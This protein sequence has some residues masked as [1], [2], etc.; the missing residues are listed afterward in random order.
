MGAGM[1]QPRH[2]HDGK[3]LYWLHPEA[4]RA[5]CA[6]QRKF[7]AGRWRVYPCGVGGEGPHWHLSSHAYREWER[8]EAA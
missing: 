7:P 4:V 6:L 3:R 2:P 1:E 5:C 8:A